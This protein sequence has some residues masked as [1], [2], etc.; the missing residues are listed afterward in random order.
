MI[1]LKHLTVE[2]F[3][4]LRAIN[5]HFPQRGSI[6]I[7]G[8][9]EAGK[10]ALLESIY[11]ALYGTAIA[12]DHSKSSVDE[13]VLYGSSQA[14]VTLTLS[15]GA[16]ELII[17]RIIERGKGQQVI[18]YVHKL[19]M[20]AEEPITRL[21]SANERI[22]TE[23]GC[24]DGETLR[25][26]CYI[27]QKSLHR[28]E[29]LSGSERETTLH[30]L[31]GLEKLMRLTEQFKLTPNDE[32]MLHESTERLKLAEVQARIPELS[33][34]LGE[35][36]AALDAVSVSED[37]TEISQQEADIAEQEL[38]L[39]QLRQERVEL[40]AR[41][42]R[43][44]QL[45]KADAT[46]G[47]IITAYD[48]I[49]EA[50]R[51]LPELEREIAELDR[52]E[53]EELPALEKRVK[54]LVDLTRSFGT[55]ERLSN[56]LLSAVNT[57]KE[58][59]K[60]LKS[61]EG[62]QEDNDE[63][64]VQ[65]SNLGVQM[66]QGQRSLNELE[67]LRRVGRPPLEARLQRLRGLNERLRA[68]EQTE[69][70]YARRIIQQGLVEENTVQLVKVRKDL[71]E[72]EQEL[73][74][75]EAEA[76]H[77]QQEVDAQEKQLQQLNI[78]RR[79]K[80]WQ[81]L[82]GLSQGLAE[83]EQH[84]MTA[85]QHQERL[86]NAALEARRAANRWLMTAIG[87][88]ALGVVLG[89]VALL[90]FSQQA[91]L[92]SA[93]GLLVL[94]LLAGAGFSIYKYNK[95]HNEE[96][97]ANRHMQD[98]IS[99]VGMMVAARETAMRTSGKRDALA[100]V[101][102]EIRSLGGSVPRSRE[103]AQ[104]L[105]QQIQDK[106]ES[107]D[108]IQQYLTEKQ[109]AALALHNQVNVTKD[110]V[111]VLR[112]ERQ[113]LED[114]RKN[115]GWDNIDAKLRSDR[116]AIQDRQNEITT[117]AGQ[118]G[119]SI[120]TFDTSVAAVASSKESTT[121]VDD[122]EM[123]IADAIKATEREIVTLDSKL[124]HVSDLKAK[125]KEQ[126]ES[127]DMLL[128]SKRALTERG[129][130]YQGVNVVEQVEHA[131][132]QQLTLRSALQSLQ[133]SLRQRVK[134][135]GVSFGQTAINS[136]EIAARKQLET[137]HISLGNRVGLQSR[138][139]Y[140]AIVLKERQ[141]SLANHYNHLARYSG[142]LGSWIVP[143]NPFAETLVMLRQR[144]AQE[145]IHADE[146]G[147]LQ[148]LENIQVQERAS[149]AQIELCRQKIEEA[150]ERTTIMLVQHNRPP[151]KSYNFTAIVSVWP[152]VGGY[153]TLDRVRLEEERESLEQELQA[154]EQQELSLSTQLQVGDRLDL[155]QAR[156]RKQL[157]ERDYETRKYGSLLLKSMSERL[158][159]KMLPRIEYY[160]Q[161]L[162]PLLTSGRYHDVRLRT[163]AEEGTASGGPFQLRVWDT[164]AGE[165]VP[166]SALSGGVTDQLSLALRLA[167]AIA[168]LP[169][170]LVAAPGFVVLDE[171]LSSFDRN[172]TQALVNVV[173][174][175]ILGQHFEQV[176]FVSHSSAFDPAMFPYHIY[177]DNGVVVESNLPVV[178]SFP[179]LAI[180]ESEAQQE[181][182]GEDE[183][184][185]GEMIE[186]E[187]VFGGSRDVEVSQVI[188]R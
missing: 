109:D 23:L 95:V 60:E 82:K 41:Q 154:L 121:T 155:E 83:A 130:H 67:E 115:E 177:L 152:L 57:I 114:Q 3:R 124:E 171:P 185:D 166:R 160:M 42:S 110:A 117:L 89:I 142:S 68:L 53:H 33:Q 188:N 24:M 76:R 99:Q 179:A 94:L 79:L 133:D 86:T 85:H 107:L 4:L 26:S 148:G 75:V 63:L 14:S 72:K 20:P 102:H 48:E 74:L 106:G 88:C 132:K 112:K 175:E 113:R 15:I 156:I 169:R 91:I 118:E 182:K 21:G 22:I 54:D 87:S 168:A 38:F 105:L 59:E 184:E 172:R 128:A 10:S 37:L 80:E 43:I 108:S 39:E 135:L 176:L 101:E 136:A 167:F 45:N 161:Q 111:A 44:Q 120:P 178:A 147:L 81:H 158:M 180:N 62:L 150:H 64:D 129:Q 9:N 144:C 34:R 183:K 36:E 140:Y 12:S 164:A 162:L 5:L 104:Q 7:Q 149:E 55:L 8:P 78:G 116:I 119:L 16:T 35:L 50:Q 170:E 17:N 32:R 11:F 126:K 145:I 30:K 56:D 28:V 139:D 19:G 31:L 47:E 98:A 6:L 71:E 90:I 2:R 66:E 131:R 52:R 151:A 61:Y 163:D 125:L 181:R 29:N 84:V 27:E 134:P 138:H 100:Q 103:E 146:S 77:T 127:L 186:A 96:Q 173:T 123:A 70:K 40:K 73:K 65:M 187:S 143:A 157:Q 13:L 51:E 159:H 49:A 25:N 137:L 46:L 1:I 92:T 122:L 69:E 174:G 153:T 58:L 165:Y 18:L 97:I 93:L 141:D